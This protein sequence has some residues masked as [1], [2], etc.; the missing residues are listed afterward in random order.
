MKLLK[1]YIK[2]AVVAFTAMVVTSCHDLLDEPPENTSFLEDTDY[3]NSDNMM[4][5][6]IGTYAGFYNR[7][8]EDF[9]LISVR[10]DDVNAG[11]L[12]DQQDYAE[13]DK[14]NYNKDYWMY[15][16][17]WQNLYNNIWDAHSAIEQIEKYQEFA[18]NPALGD[19]YIA[20]AKV[21]RAYL[22]FQLSRV[23]GDVFITTSSD[24]SDLLNTP[25]STQAEVMEHISAQMDEAMPLLPVMHPNERTDIRGGVTKYTALAIKA[26]ANLELKNYQAVAD[27]TSEIITSNEFALEADYYQLFKIPGKLNKENILELQYSDF[28]AGSGDTKT[29][30]FAFYGPENWTPA[31]TG[32]GSGWGFF[33]PSLKYIKFMLDRGETTRLETSVLFTDRGIAEIKKDPNYATL[34]DWISNTTPSNDR[35]N[36]YARAMFASGKHYLPSDQLTPGRTDYGTNKNFTCIRY[37]EILLMHAEALVQGASGTGMT[38]D[39]AVNAV[40]DRAGLGALSGVTL[41]Q[42]MDEKFAELAM[43]WGVRYYDMIRLGEYDELSYDGRT[44]TEDKTFLPYPQSQVDLYPI[45]R[46]SL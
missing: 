34:P 1:Y 39:Q 25:L 18:P 26:L 3:T 5:P 11:G 8:W 46:E 28:G 33:E 4:L 14:Y 6:L 17:L 2:I 24:P 19:Q 13:T 40:R 37:A 43:E 21:L 7:G 9:P 15:N 44:F 27:A 41:Q 12:G 32:A 31:V 10:G 42:V 16:S 36:D 38:A 23:W 30:L 22:L 35:I 20:E 29:H 45:L